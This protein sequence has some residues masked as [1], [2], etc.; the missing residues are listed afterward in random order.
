M[1]ADMEEIAATCIPGLVP[2]T[3]Q[4]GI[5]ANDQGRE[6]EFCVME[7]VEGSTLEE[8]WDHMSSENRRSV[9]TAVVDA[10][11]KLQSVRLYDAKVQTILR[12]ELGEE[13]AEVLKKAVL[14]GPWTV[15]LQDGRSLL[16]SIEQ[17]WKLKRPFCTIH[18]VAGPK[19]LVVKS[20]FEDLGSTT[21]TDS[22][23]EQWPK[24][25]VFCHNDL[26][27]RNL[28]LQFSEGI[29]TYKLAAII[30][31]EL[32]G[33]Y[34]QSYQLSLQDAYLGCGNRHIA[35]YLLLKERMKDITPPSPSQVALLRAM[36]LIYES[37]ERWLSVA[38]AGDGVAGQL[39]WLDE[40]NQDHTKRRT[41]APETQRLVGYLG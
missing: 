40:W 38:K 26:T 17:R 7:L 15:F 4:V 8:A 13:S 5:A 16:S 32:A 34:P 23:M 29:A 3:L 37:R 27:P 1:I 19:G 24:E 18:D 35:Y 2:E 31:W 12:R 30:D 39:S 33:F 20:S 14:G 25:A 6:F 22:D 21:I 9:V 28:N 36:E 41:E 11:S 10:L